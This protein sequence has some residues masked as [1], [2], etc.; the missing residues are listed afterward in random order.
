MKRLLHAFIST[1]VRQLY[2]AVRKVV[3]G[4]Q[5]YIWSFNVCMYKLWFLRVVL[6]HF[7]FDFYTSLCKSQC[8][9]DMFLKRRC[10]YQSVLDDTPDFK[11]NAPN[12]TVYKALSRTFHL[13]YT[14]RCYTGLAT[15]RLPNYFV[16]F[17]NNLY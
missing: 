14:Y 16:S 8:K 10:A 9:N 17:L 5:M 11:N 3:K 2:R 13:P 7:C 12:P 15:M 1:S 4:D 6:V